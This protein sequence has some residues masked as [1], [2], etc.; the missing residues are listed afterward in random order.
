MLEGGA[1]EEVV[2]EWNKRYAGRKRKI[3]ERRARE[4][5]QLGRGLGLAEL[6]LPLEERPPPTALV[7][8]TSRE[9]DLESVKKVKR[10]WGMSL[11]SMWGSKADKVTLERRSTVLAEEEGEKARPAE[12]NMQQRRRRERSGSKRSRSRSNAAARRVRSYSTTVS[13]QGQAGDGSAIERARYED[14]LSHANVD[15]PVIE[16][17]EEPIIPTTKTTST[18]PTQGRDT[19]PFKLNV[20]GQGKSVNPSMITLMSEREDDEEETVAGGGGKEEREEEKADDL[21]GNGKVVA[22]AESDPNEKLARP[23]PERFV[24]AS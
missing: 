7:G 22:P 6:G 19:Y 24:T 14:T 18:R 16:V 11:W 4:K 15:V 8:M 13:D 10:S 3:Q 17:S 9:R 2:E 20:E 5:R 1:G 21:V 23:Q 12:E